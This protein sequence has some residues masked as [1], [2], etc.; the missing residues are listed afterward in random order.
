MPSP[1]V[2]GWWDVCNFYCFFSQ[3][4][5]VA[6]GVRSLSILVVS[7]FALAVIFGDS[8][9]AEI[10]LVQRLSGDGG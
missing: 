7:P 2:Q 6:V 8:I 5:Y 10:S 4:G 1:E 9:G 3:K